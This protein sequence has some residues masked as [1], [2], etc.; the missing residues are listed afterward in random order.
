M[1]VTM[2]L[3][4]LLVVLLPDAFAREYTQW[5]LAQ[6]AIAH[7]GKSTIN[8]ICYSPDGARLAIASSLGIWFYD[9]ATSQ[10]ENSQNGEP[11]L[12]TGHSGEAISVA[13]SPDGKTLVSGGD[14]GEVHLWNSATGELK[15]DAQ[16]SYGRGFECSVQLRWK[17]ACQWNFLDAA[18]VGYY[19]RGSAVGVQRGDGINP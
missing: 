13:F 9:T 2:M 14:N 17:N 4:T 1:K 19:N 6:D 3:F 7:L 5:S 18:T 16:R 11:V 12:L 8:E 10:V 15:G